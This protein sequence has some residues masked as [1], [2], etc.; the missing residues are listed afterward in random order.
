CWLTSNGS[1]CQWHSFSS[2]GATGGFEVC[3]ASAQ[4]YTGMA[5]S[6][7][8]GKLHIGGLQFRAIDLPGSRCPLI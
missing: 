2:S 3:Y 6:G 5:T 1:A 4:K 7:T 8:E